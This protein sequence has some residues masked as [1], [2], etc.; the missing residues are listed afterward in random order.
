MNLDFLK[1]KLKAHQDL[2]SSMEDH[3]KEL[4]VILTQIKDVQLKQ[5]MIIAKIDGDS[6][7]T[8]SEIKAAGVSF[9]NIKALNDAL[10]RVDK[11]F[12]YLLH[13]SKLPRSYEKA[14]IEVA[15]RRKYRRLIDEEYTRIKKA[16]KKE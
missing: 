16:V 4:E 11:D 13:P 9:E 1:G 12:A 14:L 5:A 15:R 3:C 7:Q 6:A 10:A 2:A 8:R